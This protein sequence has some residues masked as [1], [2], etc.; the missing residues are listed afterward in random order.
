VSHSRTR[1]VIEGHQSNES[2]VVHGEPSFD[3]LISLLHILP[4]LPSLHI[5]LIG[6]SLLVNLRV[7]ADSSKGKHSLS[8]APETVVFFIY[9]VSPVLVEFSL[10]TVDE[11]LAAPVE[12]S[13]WGSFHYKHQ[14][15]FLSL[16]VLHSC[17]HISDVDIELDFRTERDQTVTLLSISF[18]GK[19][20]VLVSSLLNGHDGLTELDET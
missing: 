13:L 3:G 4:L 7:K 6:R 14:V 18:I 2:E 20:R 1:R 5:K 16:R 15:V 8:H 19:G 10:F 12:D 11:D 9:Y 17:V